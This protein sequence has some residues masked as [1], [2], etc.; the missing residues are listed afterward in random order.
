MWIWQEY[1]HV[2]ATQLEE[3]LSRVTHI[4]EAEGPAPAAGMMRS[5]DAM[6]L[7]D[8]EGDDDFFASVDSRGMSTSIHA[9][10]TL[11]VCSFSL[12]DGMLSAV[13]LGVVE[14]EAMFTAS[15][16][17]AL[18]DSRGSTDDGFF[19]F[20]DDLIGDVGEASVHTAHT[21]SRLCRGW[22]GF[23]VE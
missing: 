16:A 22:S 17:M 5:S 1:A 8:D 20:I 4:V 12:S 3:D 10:D 15:D 13:M 14:G 23:G 19:G 21:H 18:F 2:V 9:T 7:F 6:R 11:P